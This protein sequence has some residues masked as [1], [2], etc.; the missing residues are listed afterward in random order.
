MD[1]M[2]LLRTYWDRLGAIGCTIAG[3]I[4][5]GFGWHGV[6]QSAY[7]AGQI[8]YVVSDGFGGLLLLG[9]AAIL[10]IS[11]DLRDEWTKLDSLDQHLETLIELAGGQVREVPPSDSLQAVQGRR[12]RPEAYLPA[13]SGTRD[14]TSDGTA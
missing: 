5:L 11:A 12:A 1:I 6:S 14:S 4:V 2:N 9:V 13:S 3:V 8:P 10:W 7:P